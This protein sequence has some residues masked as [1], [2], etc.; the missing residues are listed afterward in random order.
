MFARA[1]SFDLS[2]QG[3][4]PYGKRKADKLKTAGAATGVEYAADLPELRRTI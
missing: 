2:Q 1:K 3:F 4:S